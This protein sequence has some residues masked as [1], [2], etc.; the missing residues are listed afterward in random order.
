MKRSVTATSSGSPR[1]TARQMELNRP[2]SCLVKMVSQMALK[3][4]L[5][6]SMAL[7]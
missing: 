6:L 3:K 2:A 4:E 1:T 7:G 5:I